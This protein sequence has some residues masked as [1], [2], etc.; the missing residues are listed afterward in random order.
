VRRASAV[1]LAFAAAASGAAS[2]SDASNSRDSKKDYALIERSI[3]IARRSLETS[4]P[5][6]ASLVASDA[7]FELWRG[8]AGSNFRCAEEGCTDD[9]Q[10]GVPAAR[11]FFDAVKATT[12]VVYKAAGPIC[13]LDSNTAKIEFITAGGAESVVATFTY[14]GSLLSEV[15]AY[16]LYREEGRLRGD[17]R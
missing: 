17:G 9:G 7:K 3:D 1:I 5:K 14:K 12:F 15:T 2:A 13:T 6:L 8:D 10:L 4:D 16:T 11:A